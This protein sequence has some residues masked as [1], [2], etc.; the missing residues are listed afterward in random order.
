MFFSKNKL[1]HKNNIFDIFDSEDNEIYFFG[2]TKTLDHNVVI[3][4]STPREDRK[5]V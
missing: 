3:L 2:A 1:S 4:N 5:Y